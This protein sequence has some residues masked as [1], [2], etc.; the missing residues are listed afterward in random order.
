MPPR[1]LAYRYIRKKDMPNINVKNYI[2]ILTAT[3][4]LFSSCSPQDQPLP[5]STPKPKEY[6]VPVSTSLPSPTFQPS[7]RMPSPTPVLPISLEQL[8]AK[9][10]FQEG[11]FD[12]EFYLYQDPGFSQD[13]PMTWMYSDIPG[14][15]TH[16]SWVY[17]GPGLDDAPTLWHN[18]RRS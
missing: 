18:R 10:A 6:L 8:F 9:T 11:P 12:F 16:V 5:P 4:I 2:I 1:N 15:G 3:L 17:R 13:P 14:V 7:L